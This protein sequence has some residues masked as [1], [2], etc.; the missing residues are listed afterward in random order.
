[1]RCLVIEDE[2]DIATYICRGLREAGH[3]ATSVRDAANGL[4]LAVNQRWDV[5]ILDRVLPDGIDGISI[6]ATIRGLGKTTPVLILSAL[7]SLDERIRGLRG[8]ADD[9]LTKPFAFSELLARVEVLFRRVAV[10]RDCRE[11]W[12]ADLRLD[13]RARRAER[14]GK[15][16]KLQPREFRLLEFLVRHQEQVVTRTMLLEAVWEQYFELPTNVIDVQISRLRSKIDKDFSPQLLHTIR[17]IGYMI[18]T[19]ED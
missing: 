14:A 12:I 11:L 13:L 5:I 16:I 6:V 10:V 4:F 3:T 2:G 7:T 19:I 17:G 18:S 8:G 15:P 1:M 9:Y